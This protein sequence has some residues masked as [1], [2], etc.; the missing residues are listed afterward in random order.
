VADARLWARQFGELGFDDVRIVLDGDATQDRIVAELRELVAT[1]K[2][3]DVVAFQYSGHGTY[4][5]DQGTGDQRDEGDGRDEALVPVDFDRNRFVLDDEQFRIF[6]AL[7]P[8]ALLTCFYDCCH[9]GTMARVALQRFLGQTRSLAGGEVNF[10]FLDPTPG[11]LAEY[12]R[13]R[14][15]RRGIARRS[16][17]DV[18]ALEAVVFSACRDNEVALEVGGQ[19]VFTG[20]VVR[21]LREAVRDGVSNEE[22]HRRITAAFG[23]A[24]SQH[25]GL[26]CAPHAKR[27]P[28]L[29]LAGQSAARPG[30]GGGSG[31][32][33]HGEGNGAGSNGAGDGGGD[34]REAW[35]TL[36]SGL[37]TMPR[38]E[39]RAL[40][41]EAEQHLR[42]E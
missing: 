6:D 35:N 40:I 29:R 28:L 5:P 1:A 14:A 42:S 39:L 30:A 41:D 27:W 31:G 18:D 21:L 19:G 24:P 33:G 9:S 37:Y 11:M 3:G 4:F 32:D 10:R 20:H 7:A 15:G 38:A 17:R 25:P 12:R 34:T 23:D 22:F 36:L 13:R 26:D 8:G 16:I 2:R